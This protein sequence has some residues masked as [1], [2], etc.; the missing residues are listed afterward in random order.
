VSGSTGTDRPDADHIIAGAHP[1]VTQFTAVGFDEEPP[2]LVSALATPDV[3]VHP[4]HSRAARR[5]WQ[6]PYVAR[7]VGADA[8]TAVFGSIVAAGAA[9]TLRL[10]R[11]VVLA[12]LYVVAWVLA[13]TVGGSYETRRLGVGPVEYTRVLR[14]GV[15]VFAAVAAGEIVLGMSMGRPAVLAV[16]LTILL[17]LCERLILRRRLYRARWR[18]EYIDRVIAVGP[19]ADVA[20]IAATLRREAHHGLEVVGACILDVDGHSPAPLVDGIEE[21]L[22]VPVLGGL[23]DVPAAVAATGSQVVAVAATGDLATGTLRRLA[24]SL[25]GLGT[26][27]LVSPGLVEVAGPRLTVRPYPSLPLLHVEQPRLSG[28]ARAV[29]GFGDRFGAGL[30]LLAL[31]PVF[32]AVAVAVAA[33]SPGG[34][35]F[36]Q[37][38]IGLDGRPFRLWKFRSMVSDAET[39]V[40]SLGE[41]NEKDDV[42]F[43]IRRDPRITRVGALLRRLSLDEL[44]QLFNVVGGSMSLVGPRPPLPREVE[45]YATDARRR[46]LVRPGITGLWQVSG[47]SEL[48][49]EET[50]RLDLR[51]VENWTV[52]LD[53]SILYRTLH[54]VVG[55]RGAY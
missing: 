46:L 35:F 12:P 4:P 13:L 24:W 52:G 3:P 22:G 11:D 40:S 7:L 47:R 36:K 27:V 48:S 25:E 31:S 17:T 34:V 41:Q 53:I 49:W 50:V 9:G 5:P 15:G 26:E 37:T 18:G 38:R 42:L 54:A 32:A 55:G 29:K 20:H 16:A 2:D 43:K 1:A 51:Y 14:S 45:Q 6:R 10:E 33:T 39:L 28:S 44:P 23:R 8:L 19:A 21:T 30:L